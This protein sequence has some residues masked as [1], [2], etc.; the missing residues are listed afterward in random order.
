MRKM[1]AAFC[2]ELVQMAARL[3]LKHPQAARVAV[4]T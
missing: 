4:G 1:E 3:R 2:A